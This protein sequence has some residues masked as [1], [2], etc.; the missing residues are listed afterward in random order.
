MTAPSP[1]SPTGARRIELIVILGA[2]TAAAPISIDL[3]LPALPTI[4]HAF[5]D[6]IGAVERTLASFFLGFALGQALFG[7]LADRF[8]RKPPLLWGIGIYVLT[9][10][11]CA[12]A[13]SVGALVALRFVQAVSACA[14]AVIARACVRDLFP[15]DEAP[16]VFATMMLVMGVAPLLAPLAGGY[17]LVWFGW[18]A[19]FLA[20]G[21]L[22]LAALV[23][24]QLRLRESHG[25]AHRPLHPVS[26]LIDFWRIARDRRFIGYVLAAA[27]SSGGM[28]AYV[29]A[30]PHVFI[31]LFHVPS[32]MYGWFFGANALALV[33]MSQLGARLLHRYPAQHVL[34][35]A[36]I[37]Q[38]AAGALLLASAL[39]GIGGLWSLAPCLLLYVGLNGA[40]GPTSAGLAMKPFALN[41]GMASALLG[42]LQFGGGTITSLTVGLLPGNGELA[43]AAVIAAC[44]IGGLTL[45]L[46]LSPRAGGATT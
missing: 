35:A 22:G 29:T 21:A 9:C 10:V 39:S 16:R 45:N 25:G 34:V 5:G 33:A 7:P 31:D 3:Y 14:G 24:A 41:A 42:T 27:T 38:T 6:P 46:L 18:R 2:L 32:Q 30:S 8:G 4:A 43:M 44:G 15:A 37:G 28:F 17:L 20:Q 40:I 23:A 1:A 12:F 11:A 26:L 36:Q 19:I 13:P